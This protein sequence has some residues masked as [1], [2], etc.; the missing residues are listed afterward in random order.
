MQRMLSP[1][2]TTKMYGHLLPSQPLEA[3]TPDMAQTAITLHPTK[4]QDLLV[5][6][7]QSD[8]SGFLRGQGSKIGPLNYR[9]K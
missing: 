6:S 7:L 8:R 4:L 5:E 9:D 1:S 2:P 3:Y